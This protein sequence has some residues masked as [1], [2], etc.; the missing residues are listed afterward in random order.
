MTAAHVVAY[1]VSRLPEGLQLAGEPVPVLAVGG[2]EPAGQRRPEPGRR[3]ADQP[4]PGRSRALQRGEQ[5]IPDRRG[6]GV[7]VDEDRG[8][9]AQTA[10]GVVGCSTDSVSASLRRW[11]TAR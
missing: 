11:D 5:R 6:L 2:A 8:H 1:Q 3:Q 4:G 10:I 9:R 7:S